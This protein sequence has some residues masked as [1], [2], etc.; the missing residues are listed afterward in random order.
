MTEKLTLKHWIRVMGLLKSSKLEYLKTADGQH[1]TEVQR[2]LHRQARLRH[3]FFQDLELQ[4]RAKYEEKEPFQLAG[5]QIEQRFVT[6]L[7]QH[8]KSSS[9]EKCAEIDAE[10]LELIE[11]PE[12]DGIIIQP[13]LNAIQEA[14]LYLQKIQEKKEAKTKFWS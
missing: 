6:S 8:T 11:R 3:H 9:L 7:Q 4:V 1:P 5:V 12:N 10:I 2:F 14:G 13:L